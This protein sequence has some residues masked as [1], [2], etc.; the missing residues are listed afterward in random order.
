MGDREELGHSWI[1]VRVRT[2][3]VPRAVSSGADGRAV[4]PI[5]VSFGGAEAVCEADH[6]GIGHERPTSSVV[7]RTPSRE[8]VSLL[9]VLSALPSTGR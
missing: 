7:A 4:G 1:N 2:Q 6:A 5:G 9:D 3:R 8:R